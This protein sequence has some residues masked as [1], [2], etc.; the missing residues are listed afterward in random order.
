MGCGHQ[1]EECWVTATEEEILHM[2]C[3]C[4][5]LFTFGV[6]MFYVATSRQLK[7]LDSVTRSPIYSHFSE[8]VSGL[9]VIRAFEHQQR[10][11]KHNEVG[12]DTNQKCVFSWIVSNRWGCPW[13]FTQIYALGLCVFDLSYGRAGVASDVNFTVPKH[14]CCVSRRKYEVWSQRLDACAYSIYQVG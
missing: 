1:G 13:V 7:R 8:T 2:Q 10:F 4:D 6:Q 3:D 12:I 9:S 14:T 11:L 5:W